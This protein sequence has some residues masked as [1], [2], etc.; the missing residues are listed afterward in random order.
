MKVST[1]S[2]EEIWHEIQNFSTYASIGRKMGISRQRVSVIVKKNGLSYAVPVEYIP[3]K[4]FAER[5]SLSN[6]SIMYHLKRGRLLGVK[7]GRR[8]HIKGD[9]E[10]K[11][12]CV[13]CRQRVSKRRSKYCSIEC[14]RK[15]ESSGKMRHFQDRGRAAPSSLQACSTQGLCRNG[16]PNTQ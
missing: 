2:C 8:W 11:P 14:M 3:L 9:T 13:V 7:V 1:R 6:T 16:Y 12:R 5:E 15:Y 10:L 4:E